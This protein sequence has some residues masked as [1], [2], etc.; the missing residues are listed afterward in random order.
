MTK[1]ESAATVA[2]FF[3]G[4]LLDVT[5]RL[6]KRARLRALQARIRDIEDTLQ[7]LR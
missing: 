5:Y 4:A 6:N 2:I 7:R 1:R 3:L